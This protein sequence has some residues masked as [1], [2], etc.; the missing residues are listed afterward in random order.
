MIYSFGLELQALPAVYGLTAPYLTDDCQQVAKSG[1]RRLWSAD[2]DTCIVPR[3][4]TRLGDRSFAVAGSRFWNTLPTELRQ[5]D[6]E[7]ITYRRLLKT[8]L[9][10]CDPGA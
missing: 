8:H 2:V 5:P 10:E 1:C 3:T 4:N 9:F 6:I 7:L